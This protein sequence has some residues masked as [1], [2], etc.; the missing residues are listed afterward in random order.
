MRRFLNIMARTASI[1]ARAIEPVT[2]ATICPVVLGELLD[3]DWGEVWDWLV[4]Q[5]GSA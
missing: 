5:T 3:W 1:I 4:C 2:A